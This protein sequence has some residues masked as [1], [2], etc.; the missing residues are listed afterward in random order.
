MKRALTVA[1]A[2]V[3]LAAAAEREQ[4]LGDYSQEIRGKIAAKV[5]EVLSPR[6][7]PA[8][9]EGT[10]TFSAEDRFFLQRGADGL[11][12]IADGLATVPSPGDVVV[13][14]GAPWRARRQSP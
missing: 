13:V 1:A 14:S 2:L 4:S 12:V 5:L 10:V 3:S 8:E 9:I 11:K 7:S 6:G